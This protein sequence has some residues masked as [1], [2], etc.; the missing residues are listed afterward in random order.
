MAVKIDR[1]IGK[2]EKHRHAAQTY[3]DCI[4]RAVKIMVAKEAK[5]N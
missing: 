4:A 2:R 1:D 5:G 3:I